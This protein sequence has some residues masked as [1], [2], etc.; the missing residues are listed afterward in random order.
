MFSFLII[1][2]GL[3]EDRILYYHFPKCICCEENNS[4][5]RLWFSSGQTFDSV[6]WHVEISVTTGQKLFQCSTNKYY[7]AY[8][9]N[10]CLIMYELFNCEAGGGKCR[11]GEM[12][13]WFCQIFLKY[14]WNLNTFNLGW[15]PPSHPYLDDWLVIIVN[16]CTWEHGF[17]WFLAIFSFSTVK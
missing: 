16:G 14:Q 17:D 15:G 8:S 11:G 3:Y 5:L 9:K 13:M 12:N 2:V 10:V 4:S 6:Y 1:P 7:K